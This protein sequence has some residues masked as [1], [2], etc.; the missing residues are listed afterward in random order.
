M[1][2]VDEHVIQVVSV[3][4]QYRELQD[5]RCSCGGFWRIQKARTHSRDCTLDGMRHEELATVCSG[6]GAKRTFRFAIFES[7]QAYLLEFG[8]ALQDLGL[9]DLSDLLTIF[10]SSSPAHA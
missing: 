6:C 7:N 10:E 2:K 4:Q 8:Q 3:R 9:Q 1:T 5:R